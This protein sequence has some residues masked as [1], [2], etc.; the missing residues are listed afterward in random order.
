M[1]VSRTGLARVLGV[2]MEHRAEYE[3]EIFLELTAV[4]AACAGLYAACSAGSNNPAFSGLA[5]LLAILLLV[6]R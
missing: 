3:K 4:A 2:M 5:I 1:T 6:V